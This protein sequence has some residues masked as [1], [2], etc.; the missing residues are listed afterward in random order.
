MT[1]NALHSYIPLTGGLQTRTLR[2]ERLEYYCRLLIEATQLARSSSNFYEVLYGI[3]DSMLRITQADAAVM[4][5]NDEDGNF[6]YVGGRNANGKEFVENDMRFVPALAGR[7]R[8]SHHITVIHNLAQ[9]SALRDDKSAG[10]QYLQAVIALSLTHG[11]ATLGFVQLGSHSALPALEDFELSILKS[12]AAVLSLKTDNALAASQIEQLKE[13]TEQEL[14]DRTEQLNAANNWLANALEKTERQLAAKRERENALLRFLTSMSHELRAPAQL[15]MGH[16]HLVLE[17]GT[18]HLSSPQ[19][20]SLG[21]IVRASEHVSQL[22]DRLVE[23]SP[24]DEGCFAFDPVSFDVRPL[25]NETLALCRGLTKN[26]PIQLLY[27]YPPE[28]P[29]VLGD[30][31]CVRQVL[32]NLLAN[33]CR[34]TREGK[35]SV[36]ASLQPGYVVI[37]VA[38]TGVGIEPDRLNTIFDQDAHSEDK[39]ATSRSGLGL[40]ISKQLVELHGGRLWAHS[41]PGKGSVF[42]FSLPVVMD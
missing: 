8:G 38:D 2:T 42:S 10:T 35:I 27:Y 12:L 14:R 6:Q 30:A 1:A 39:P 22:V 23:P 41:A 40:P 28:L 24:S 11:A 17:D 25:I 4:V 18:A 3:L 15:I 29:N 31:T 13:S 16:A 33:A 5:L 20:S 34:F 37:S 7:L 21:S 19:R 32:I 9:D 36:N 26:Q